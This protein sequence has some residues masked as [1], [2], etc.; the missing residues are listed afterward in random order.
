MRQCCVT[1]QKKSHKRNWE[2]KDNNKKITESFIDIERFNQALCSH[3][4]ATFIFLF[5]HCN[6][7]FNNLFSYMC[8]VFCLQFSIIHKHEFVFV[9]VY[10]ASNTVI[11][12]FLSFRLHFDYRFRFV[13]YYMRN[14]AI[15]CLIERSY[16][17][18]T[19]RTNCSRQLP[20][21]NNFTFLF[22]FSLFHS[23]DHL[24]AMRCDAMQ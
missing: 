8:S 2:K 23:T 11:T 5:L 21:Y 18:L 20:V 22:I 7:P 17:I 19:L 12:M 14:G 13:L 9:V 3:S 15:V 4:W 1:A 10:H 16:F 6:F 24:D